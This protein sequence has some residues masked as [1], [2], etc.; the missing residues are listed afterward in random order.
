MDGI[1]PTKQAVQQTIVLVTSQKSV[2]FAFLLTFVFGPLGLLYASVPG[3][4]F[5]MVVAI[6][7]GVV[8]FGLALIPVWLGS[9]IWAVVAVNRSNKRLFAL[10]GVSGAGTGDISAPR[11]AARATA[12]MGEAAS[13]V[14]EPAVARPAHQPTVA[15]T[16]GFDLAQWFD[17]NKRSVTLAAAGVVGLLLAIVALRF[18][19]SIDFGGRTAAREAGSKTASTQDAPLAIQ[20]SPRGNINGRW[21]LV[22]GEQHPATKQVVQSFLAVS[23]ENDTRT[24][25]WT[26]ELEGSVEH[27]IQ[28]TLSHG[29]FVGDYYG[30]KGN[31]TIAS[32]G[33]V[34]LSLTIDPF[35]EFAPIRNSIFARVSQDAPQNDV[36]VGDASD[37]GASATSGSSA[38][39]THIRAV[40]A[41]VQRGAA[42][43]RRTTHDV[44]GPATQAGQLTGLYEGTELRQLVVRNTDTAWRGTEEYYF[45]AGQLIF[46]YVVREP[47]ASSTGG[48]STR[49]EYR[50]YF[51]NGRL[52]RRIRSQSPS[53]SVEDLSIDPQ[54]SQLV[55]N[56]KRLADC[57]AAVETDVPACSAPGK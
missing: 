32:V 18:V 5:M 46:I 28:L 54:L 23:G 42:R 6:F 1:E 20:P 55:A 2:A 33:G 40:F 51:E 49:I 4:L 38:A 37:E 14:D 36:R 24:A 15:S 35:A 48:A 57:A 11:P 41:G 13:P 25:I 10:H 53:T 31:V 34:R 50:L 22:E 44:Y 12:P 19:L 26:T 7:L 47:R 27:T 8:T 45:D 16:P 17:G 3:A 56:A 30:G 52:I 39:I 9:I 21:K 43:Y 29:V